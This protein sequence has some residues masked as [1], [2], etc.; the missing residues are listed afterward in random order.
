MGGGFLFYGPQNSDFRVN[1]AGNRSD[2]GCPSESG[3]LWWSLR[4]VTAV[5]SW[6]YRHYILAPS[7]FRA[8]IGSWQNCGHNEVRNQNLCG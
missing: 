6:G 3:H 4:L 5:P 8:E 1:Q 2:D 7:S